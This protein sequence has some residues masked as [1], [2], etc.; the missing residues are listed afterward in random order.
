MT[1][2]HRAIEFRKFLD[3]IDRDAP[4]AAMA[5]SLAT[6][7]SFNTVERSFRLIRPA[8]YTGRRD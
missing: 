5:P 2:R 7:R 8:P 4:N 1:A 3:L 6:L